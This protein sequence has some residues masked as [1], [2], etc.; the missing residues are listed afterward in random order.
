[1]QTSIIVMAVAIFMFLIVRAAFAMSSKKD[2]T[3]GA[4]QHR[5]SFKKPDIEMVNRQYVQEQKEEN[6]FTLKE[7]DTLND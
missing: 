7:K 2:K 1:M 3:T 4:N 6:A 5:S